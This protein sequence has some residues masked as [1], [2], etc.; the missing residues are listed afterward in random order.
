M[1]RVSQF[2]A[3]VVPSAP[4]SW[5]HF[6]ESL[7]PF[8]SRGAK[9]SPPGSIL[10]WRCW[11]GNRLAGRPAF[12]ADLSPT[13]HLQPDTPQ[14]PSQPVELHHS[15]SP[16]QTPRDIHTPSGSRS[17]ED[18]HWLEVTEEGSV[19]PPQRLLLSAALAPCPTTL[20]CLSFWLCRGGCWACR[21]ER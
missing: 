2:P 10:A 17:P 16:Q 19:H 12:Q 8:P 5:V 15:P 4:H 1:G 7:A 13:C 20:A 21:A 14:S 6:P 9:G 18:G 11:S 3:T